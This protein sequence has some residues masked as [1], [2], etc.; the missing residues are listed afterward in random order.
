MSDRSPPYPSPLESN[1]IV[2]SGRPFNAEPS[3]KRLCASFITP[4]SDFYVRC[5]GNIP[6]LR[7]DTYRL[8]LDGMAGPARDVSLPDLRSYFARHTVTAVMQCAGNRRA[9][10]H[11]VKPVSG[12][13]WA[14]GAIGNAVWTGARLA[15]VLRWAGAPIDASLHVAFACHDDCEVAGENFRYGV[16]IP[17]PKAM[18]PDVLLADEMNGEPLSAEHGFPLRAVVPGFAGARCPKWLA[19]ITVQKKPSEARPQ[20]RLPDYAPSS[21]EFRHRIHRVKS[22]L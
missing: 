21:A 5:H 18:S 1:L 13:A 8:R 3:L 2:H 7:E 14:G 4:R 6:I 9:E 19:S 17:M 15:E 22:T 20:A 11:Q 10:L 12:D 16:S